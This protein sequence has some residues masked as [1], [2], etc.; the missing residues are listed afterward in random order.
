MWFYGA[1][2]QQNRDSDT[3]THTKPHTII[4]HS[5]LHLLNC[6]VFLFKAGSREGDGEKELQNSSEMV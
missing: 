6:K 4:D 3:H 5:Q 2:A 1:D